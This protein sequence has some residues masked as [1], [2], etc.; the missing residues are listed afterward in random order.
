MWTVVPQATDTQLAANAE[1]MLSGHMD[2]I[3]GKGVHPCH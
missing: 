1:L 3:L 2:I